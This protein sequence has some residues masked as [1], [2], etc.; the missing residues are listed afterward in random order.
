MEEE[1]ERIASLIQ[2]LSHPD[3]KVTR[4]AADAALNLLQKKG[5]PR[6]AR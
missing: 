5:P 1:S 3:K 6:I 4:E 2:S